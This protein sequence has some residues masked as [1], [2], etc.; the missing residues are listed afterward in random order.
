MRR[1]AS[2]L[3]PFSLL[4]LQHLTLSL[5][6]NTKEG[7]L[8][9]L[10]HYS[11]VNLFAHDLSVSDYTIDPLVDGHLFKVVG[12]T[13]TIGDST[14]PLADGESIYIPGRFD[15]AGVD[16]TGTGTLHVIWH[17]N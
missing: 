8:A 14:F 9:A 1:T 15:S 16:I 5:L 3:Q 13:A 10:K 11:N 17:T 7:T 2:A 6:M 12:G 4:S